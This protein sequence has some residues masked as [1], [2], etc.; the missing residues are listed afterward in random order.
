MKKVP[1][2]MLW[3]VFAAFMFFK[4]FTNVKLFLFL[5]LWSTAL[6]IHLLIK[7]GLPGKNKRL[8][9]VILSAVST[10]ATIPMLLTQHGKISY[11]YEKIRNNSCLSNDSNK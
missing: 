10:A 6:G 9:S 3:T 1:F 5:A 2:I 7:C 4:L 8:L 11:K